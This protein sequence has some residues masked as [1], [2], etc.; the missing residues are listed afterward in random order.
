M[1][2][3]LFLFIC[4]LGGCSAYITTDQV[5]RL[6]HPPTAVVILGTQTTLPTAQTN[7]FYRDMKAAFQQCGL[8]AEVFEPD[9]LTLDPAKEREQLTALRRKINADLL[10]TYRET[11]FASGVANFDALVLNAQ[12]AVVWRGH[13]FVGQQGWIN[14]TEGD[15]TGRDLVGR[16]AHDGLLKSCKL[17]N[18]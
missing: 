3:Y 13:F 17:A 7:D 10:F 4:L 9:P 5:G 2:R 11:S 14:P 16:L 18:S 12:N 15:G 8:V 6:D 1:L